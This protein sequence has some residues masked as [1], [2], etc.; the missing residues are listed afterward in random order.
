MC[1][2]PLIPPSVSQMVAAGEKTGRVGQVLDRVAEFC[3][4]DLDI[5]IKTV[6][7]FIE[8]AMIILMGVIIGGIAMALL[9][10]VFS[11]SRIVAG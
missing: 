10:P 6:T 8:P 9:L 2:Y 7:T 1:Q 5:S 4:E 11:L 3:E